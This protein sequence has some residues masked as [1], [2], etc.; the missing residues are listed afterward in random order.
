MMLFENEFKLPGLFLLLN[1][2]SQK[3][4]A[5][6]MFYLVDAFKH[7]FSFS[8]SKSKIF[9]VILEQDGILRLHIFPPCYSE[10]PQLYYGLSN[11]K[12]NMHTHTHIYII[13]IIL[14]DAVK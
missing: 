9:F 14:M 6:P 4:K 10:I 13:Y 11:E 2:Y 3:L 12:S 1:V 5:K 8:F 7:V